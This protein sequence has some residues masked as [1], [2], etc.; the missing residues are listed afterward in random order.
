METVHVC[1]L[2]VSAHL[3]QVSHLPQLCRRMLQLCFAAKLQK[4]TSP[5]TPPLRGIHNHRV[6]ISFLQEVDWQN[7]NDCKITFQNSL[8]IQPAI[9]KKEKHYVN[10]T[11]DSEAVRDTSL[12]RNQTVS[13]AAW[14]S[15]Q[16]YVSKHLKRAV[17]TCQTD[18]R[19]HGLW[20]KNPP[21]YRT[22]RKKTP[23]G[24]LI[25]TNDLPAARK[26]YR[27]CC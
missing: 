26:Q 10:V 27:Q 2:V 3:K 4:I 13:L 25:Q 18:V 15:Q 14:W 21:R 22:D 7:I 9:D 17:Q 20:E 11:S 5:L 16:C 19:L 1:F 12:Q 23:A 24:C 8:L 6:T